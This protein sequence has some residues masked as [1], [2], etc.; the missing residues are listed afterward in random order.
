MNKKRIQ[1]YHNM[2]MN[3]AIEISKMSHAK[4][5]K[6]GC[7]IVK[8]HNILSYGFNGM[9]TGMPN[10]CEYLDEN[11]ELITKKEV[12]HSELNA[13]S[14]AAKHGLSIDGASMYVTL[15]PCLQC[16]LLIIQSGIKIV[17]YRYDYRDNYGINLLQLANINVIK[18]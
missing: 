17:Y 7:V 16:S 14:K 8:N 3:L 13:I 12:L 6:V 2:Y 9:P 11:K 15:C 10:E 1:Q 4:R 18:T 5:N